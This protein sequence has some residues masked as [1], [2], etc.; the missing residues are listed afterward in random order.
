MMSP[1]GFFFQCDVSSSD[2]ALA[3]NWSVATLPNVSNF[4]AKI[5]TAEARGCSAA[6]PEVRQVFGGQARKTFRRLLPSQSEG[7]RRLV[8]V[9]QGNIGQGIIENFFP[10]FIAQNLSPV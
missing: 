7:T 1:G 2:F 5:W 3:A 9:V 6:F 8:M 10:V 4:R